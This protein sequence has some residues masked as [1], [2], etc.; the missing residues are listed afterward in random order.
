MF[1]IRF[2][3]N[4]NM[5]D[6]IG[7]YMKEIFKEYNNLRRNSQSETNLVIKERPQYWDVVILTTFDSAQRESFEQQIALKR[8]SGHFPDV[9]I[10][11]IADPVGQKLGVG[12]STLHVLTE[13][14]K[15]YSSDLHQKKLLI[16]H[17]GGSSQR[18]PSYSVIGKIFAPLPCQELIVGMSIPQMLDLKLAMYLPFCQ[19]LQP[20]VFVTCADDIETYCLNPEELNGKMLQAADVA[21]LAHPSDIQTGKDHGVYVFEDQDSENMDRDRNCVMQCAEVLQKPTESIMRT[22]GAVLTK[23]DNGCTREQV[24]SDSVFWL[25]AKLY[26]KLLK[27]Y[28]NNTPLTSELDAYAHFLPCLGSRMKNAK[29][30]DFADFRTE[31]LP[32]LQDSNFQLVLLNKSKFYHLGTMQE[33]LMHFNIL[34]VFCRE[35]GIVKNTSNIPKPFIERNKSSSNDVSIHEKMAIETYFSDATLGVTVLQDKAQVVIENC[36]IDLP[37]E[38]EGHTIISNC[39]LKKCP[40][41]RF[42]YDRVSLFQGFLY[43]TVPITYENQNLYVTI[44]FDINCNM[45]KTSKNLSEIELYGTTLSDV[46]C[47]L[48]YKSEDVMPKNAA[49]ISLWT[50][51]IF[52][53]KPSAAESFW[54]THYNVN[55]VLNKLQGTPKQTEFDGDDNMVL[56]SMYE[57]TL[58]KNLEIL[59]KDREQLSCLLKE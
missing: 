56:L 20:G 31:M 39:T 10:H 59:L 34:D 32:L 28:S 40:S 49:V 2:E 52:V 15:I 17:S 53:G 8:Q 18:L 19:L 36:F 46:V 5:A 21:A 1:L 22:R 33:Y 41:V 7:N 37:L 26:D 30:S 55:L 25:S 54:W 47:Y 38:I 11:V 51:K 3:K 44:A 6:D 12:G 45:K 57:I 58:N 16:I 50:A 14:T 27:W 9:P 24:W 23:E 48:G 13:M 43:H 29:P 42:L 35:L 4:I